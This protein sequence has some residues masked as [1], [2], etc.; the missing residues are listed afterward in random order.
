MHHQ[1]LKAALPYEEPRTM[2]NVLIDTCVWLD[3]AA[4]PRQRG[5]LETLDAF[6]ALGHIQLLVPQ[7]V[8][9]EFKRNRDRVAK[10]SARGI[11]SQVQQIKEAVRSLEMDGRRRNSLLAGLDDVKHKVP[12]LGGA[13]EQALSHAEHL[14]KQAR[15]IESSASAK[16]AAA[17][18]ALARKAPC[19]HENKN[20][21]ADAVLIE[22]YAEAVRTGTKGERFAFVTHNKNDFSGLNHRQPH[23]DIAPLFTKIK[24]LYFVNLSELLAR[25]DPSAYSEIRWEQSWN[26]EPRSLSELQEAEDRLHM[27]I[28]HNR[29]MVRVER[30]EEGKLKVVPRDEWERQGSTNAHYIIDT[31]WDGALKAAEKVRAKYGAENLGPWDDFEWG[32]VNGKLSAIR[33]VMGDDWDML[34]T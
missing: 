18:R 12:L 13:A 3:L 5:M 1:P 28:W 16:V 8:L 24:S 4:D 34:D 22:L 25:I 7:L 15:V 33:W 19:H 2:F 17:D 26:Q 27:S 9:E 20:S 6:I 32:M 11:S 31:I 23:D 30:I 29:H 10:A 14:L 21:V